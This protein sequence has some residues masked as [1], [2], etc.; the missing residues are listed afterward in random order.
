MDIGVLVP[1]AIVCRQPPVVPLVSLW[2][3]LYLGLEKKR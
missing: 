3:L 1:T 2:F